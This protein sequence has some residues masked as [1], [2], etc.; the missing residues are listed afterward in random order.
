MTLRDIG[1]TVVST[2]LTSEN[3]LIGAGCIIGGFILLALLEA[4][5]V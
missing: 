4:L 5:N 3:F 2:D 1:N